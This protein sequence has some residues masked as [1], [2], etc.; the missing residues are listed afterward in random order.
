MLDVSLLFPERPR[1]LK[2]VEYERLVSLGAFEEEKV[3]LVD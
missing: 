3:E 2:R 1:G